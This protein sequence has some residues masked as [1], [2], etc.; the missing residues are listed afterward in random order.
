MGN[1]LLILVGCVIFILFV[2]FLHFGYDIESLVVAGIFILYSAEH[3][4]NFF[5][6]S[7]FKVAKLISGTVLHR[8]FALCFPALLIGLGYLIVEGT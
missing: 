2:T 5:S 7:S 3:I 1:F 4:F 6:R 8:P